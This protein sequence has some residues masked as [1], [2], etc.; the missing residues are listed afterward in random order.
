MDTYSNP[1]TA[2]NLPVTVTLIYTDTDH[3]AMPEK[4]LGLYYWDGGSSAWVDA[5]TTC[6]GD[7]TRD[8]VGNRLVLPLCHLTLSVTEF[9]MFGTSLRMFMPVMQR[10]EVG[11]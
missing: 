9:G 10:W 1:V 3:F 6:P 5:V 2:F 8:L 11:W 7:Y 4:T